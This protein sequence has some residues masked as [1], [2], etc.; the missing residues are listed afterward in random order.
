MRLES[1]AIF[2][3][4]VDSLVW[5]DSH[6]SGPAAH[7]LVCALSPA[8]RTILGSKLSLRTHYERELLNLVEC[9]FKTDLRLPAMV[10]V[11]RSSLVVA[12][13]VSATSVSPS[14]RDEGLPRGAAAS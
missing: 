2:Q 1:Q 11:F 3:A 14:H 4:G 13:I 8:L 7:N 5:D 12:Q 6:V 10:E 9:I